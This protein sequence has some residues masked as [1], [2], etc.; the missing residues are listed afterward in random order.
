MTEGQADVLKVLN[1][2][3]R[4][5]KQLAQALELTVDAVSRRCRRLEDR[6]WVRR[7]QL[8]GDDPVEW[9]ITEQ[10]RKALSGH[11]SQS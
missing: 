5:T 1:R 11:S 10:G 3:P 7:V 9:Q 2:Q 4:K 8:Y 6:E